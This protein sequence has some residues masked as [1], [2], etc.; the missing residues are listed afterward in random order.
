M[1][2]ELLSGLLSG[3][4][5]G[6]VRGM[7]AGNTAFLSDLTLTG[8]ELT[9]YLSEN[10]IDP[11]LLVFHDTADGKRLSLPED[12]WA[13]VQ[14]IELNLFFDDGSGYIDMGLDGLYTLTEDGFIADTD[15]TW[16]AIDGQPVP[17]YQLSGDADS[18]TGYVPALLNG[19]RVQLLISF[20]PEGYG[21]LVGARADYVNGETETIAKSLS[22]LPIG[23][24][25]QLLCD[26][27]TYEGQYLETQYLGDP[28]TVTADTLKVTDVYIDASNARLTYR[29]TDIYNQE[30]WTEAYKI[31]D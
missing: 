7:D 5:Y 29:L 23:A 30:Y 17:Y 4:S 9:A 15:G 31:S 20:D 12:Q 6:R 2:T 28:I 26:Y 24:Q 1:L 27:Y 18:R 22:G 19:D 3:G 21:Y 8:E 10:M 25:L 16:L 11:D 14:D 13:L